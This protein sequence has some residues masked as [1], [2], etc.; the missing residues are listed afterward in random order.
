MPEGY[1]DWALIRATGWGYGQILD[2]PTH[3][4]RRMRAWAVEEYELN[5]QRRLREARG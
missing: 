2:Q 5:R 1:A 4:L 3:W